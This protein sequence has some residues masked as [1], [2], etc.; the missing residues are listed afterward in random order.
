MANIRAIS[1]IVLRALALL[2]GPQPGQGVSTPSRPADGTD[3]H[4][5]VAAR[6]AVATLRSGRDPDLRSDELGLVPPAPRHRAR[7]C[8]QSTRRPAWLAACSS[9]TSSAAR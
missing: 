1:F 4:L 3:T 7:C 6:I 9:S 5:P 2:L 8:D